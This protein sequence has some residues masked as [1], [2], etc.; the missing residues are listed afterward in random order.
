[1]GGRRM[2]SE[3]TGQISVIKRP[4]RGRFYV[5]TMGGFRSRLGSPTYLPGNPEAA[6]YLTSPFKLCSVWLKNE[7]VIQLIQS[8]WIPYQA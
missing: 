8:K 4:P 2:N 1:M 5:Q 3:E 6:K 7:E